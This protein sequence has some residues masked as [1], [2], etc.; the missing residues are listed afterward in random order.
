MFQQAIEYNVQVVNI[1]FRVFNLEIMNK[2]IIDEKDRS[3]QNLQ[4]S[5]E[6]EQKLKAEL[7]DRNNENNKILAELQAT[8]QK[9]NNMEMH[10]N[11]LEN[12]RI[13]RDS[14]H[15]TLKETNVN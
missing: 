13:K 7:Q 6:K 2:Q 8:K 11:N 12:I 9:I 10:S 15:A 5:L 3:I 4:G 14:L 1:L